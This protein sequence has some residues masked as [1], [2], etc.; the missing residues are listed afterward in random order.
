MTGADLNSAPAP[1]TLEVAGAH[2]R[3]GLARLMLLVI[4]MTFSGGAAWWYVRHELPYVNRAAWVP[5]LPSELLLRHDAKGSGYFGASRSGGRHHTGVDLLSEIGQPVFA[6]RSG[7]VREARYHTGF[8]FFI[9]VD[10]GDGCSTLYAHLSRLGVRRGERV[11]QGELIGAVGKS[12]NARSKL[13]AA[14]LH[15]EVRRQGEP[16]DPMS[17]GYFQSHIVD[18]A[19]EAVTVEP[20]R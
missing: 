9:E 1:C 5:P 17:F 10:H 12:G 8:G 2:Q 19:R 3:R 6:V 13:V 14:H 11:R 4:P 7:R 20:S 18:P 16:V 15:F